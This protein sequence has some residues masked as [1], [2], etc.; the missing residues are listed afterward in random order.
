MCKWLAVTFI[1]G[2]H[3]DRMHAEQAAHLI[4]GDDVMLV[5]S[6][7]SWEVAEVERRTR[8][9]EAQAQEEENDV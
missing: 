2:E 7:A 6:L 9:R 4:F 8:E 1:P 3:P 5:Q